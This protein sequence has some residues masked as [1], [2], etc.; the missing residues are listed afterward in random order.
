[1][2]IDEK[3][4]QANSGDTDAM[5]DLVNHYTDNKDWN[6]AIDWADKASD[7]GDSNGM[8]KA[9]C[10]HSLRMTSILNS[11]M[12]FWGLLKEDAEATQKNAAVLIGSCRKGYLPLNDDTYSYLLKLL[13][14]AVYCE[15]LV[16]YCDKSNADNARA[17]HLLTD[18][19][20]AREQA[21]CGL[22]LFE[23]ERYDE[24][25]KAFSGV[26]TDTSYV[27]ESKV[28]AEQIIF[29]SAMHSFSIMTRVTGSLDRSVAALSKGIEGVTDE[30]LKASLGRELSR[31]K[32]KMFG[33]WKYA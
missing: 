9:A 30:D 28:P 16:C 10:L 17:V 14:D 19:D 11:G 27:S 4:T 21:L 2:D 1:M 15:A 24:A 8:Y 25:D 31:Y 29:A 12:P 32:K 22:C 13:K 3:I 23:L 20:T 6:T 5:I 7:T 26:F 33:G 18:M